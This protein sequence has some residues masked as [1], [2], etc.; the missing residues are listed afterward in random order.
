MLIWTYGDNF[1]SCMFAKFLQLCARLSW[2]WGCGSVNCY[3]ELCADRCTRRFV[4]G[5]ILVREGMMIKMTSHSIYLISLAAKAIFSWGYT[6]SMHSFT[7]FAVLSSPYRPSPTS[8]V[9]FSW[10]S[11][12]WH[13]SRSW[14][15]DSP[16]VP[17]DK[18]SEWSSVQG[19]HQETS[20]HGNR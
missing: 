20:S 3:S 6:L 17:H 15:R 9:V 18:I 5:N 16:H 1:D 10:S 13:C 12:P 4:A 19:S 7:W 14:I 11:P 8:E 2:I